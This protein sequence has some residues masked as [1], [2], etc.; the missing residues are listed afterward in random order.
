MDHEF[1]NC[2]ICF[3][4]L[5]NSKDFIQRQCECVLKKEPGNSKFICWKCISK[6]VNG[7]NCCLDTVPCPFCNK[8][9]FPIISE[10]EEEKEQQPIEQVMRFI[11]RT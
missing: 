11:M 2:G 8:K 4:P 5:V 7:K 9:M 6:C 1:S 3:Y 10:F